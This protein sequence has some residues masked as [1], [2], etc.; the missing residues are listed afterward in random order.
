MPVINKEKERQANE[1]RH[2]ASCEPVSD[3]MPI[4]QCTDCAYF[5]IS[6]K[7]VKGQSDERCFHPAVLH[8]GN[9]AGCVGERSA[10]GSCGPDGLRFVP[11]SRSR[12]RLDGFADDLGDGRSVVVRRSRLDECTDELRVSFGKAV[13]QLVVDMEDGSIKVV[14]RCEP[15]LSD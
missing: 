5:R 4:K 11:M 12:D 6:E 8:F 10:R 14:C 1:Q 13:T 9:G 2:K 15:G 3:N 7:M